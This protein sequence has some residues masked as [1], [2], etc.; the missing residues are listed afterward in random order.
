MTDTEILVKNKVVCILG[1]GRSGTSITTRVI[2]LMGVFLGKS[3]DMMPPDKDVNAEGY[4]EHLKIVRIHDEILNEFNSSWESTKPL[5]QKWWKLP[6]IEK[7]KTKLIEV[8][9]NE[10][11]N[12]SIWGFKDPRTCVLLPLWKEIFEILY[13]E[14]LFVIPIRN[15]IDVANSLMKRDGLLLNYSLRIWYYH[16]INILEGTKD[17]SRIFIKYDDMLENPDSNLTRLADFLSIRISEED[18]ENIKKSLKPNLRHSITQEEKL[19]LIGSKKV[20]ELYDICMKFVQDS[21][22][23]VDLKLHTSEIYRLYGDLMEVQYADKKY[24]A[25]VTSLYIDYGMGYNEETSIKQKIIIKEN[26]NFNIQFKLGKSGEN[27]KKLRWDPLEGMFCKCSIDGALINGN[28]T[29]IEYSNANYSDGNYFDFFNIDPIFFLQNYYN[30][31]DIVTIYGKINFYTS[32]QLQK[33]FEQEKLKVRNINEEFNKT[34]LENEN[35]RLAREKEMGDIIN[36]LEDN[37]RILYDNKM[38]VDKEIQLVL[39]ST[40]WKITK[41]FRAIK[42]LFL[43]LLAK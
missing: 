24:E 12:Q 39:N 3:E 17:Y 7:Y 5:P 38:K 41:P 25:Y 21:Y 11:N 30:T 36:K 6:K 2:N 35:N 15:P 37:Y 16:M 32:V 9:K 42:R 43:K 34:I 13:I 31:V 19:K 20:I 40:S 23:E 33:F 4:W 18:K 14:P 27:V 28:S 29:K 26:G 8:I 22:S 1:M 10:F